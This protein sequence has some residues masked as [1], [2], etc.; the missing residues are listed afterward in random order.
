M[1]ATIPTQET[2]RRTTKD[3][4]KPARRPALA[5]TNPLRPRSSKV[6][7]VVH[8]DSA[9]ARQSIQAVIESYRKS[10]DQQS[11]LWESARVCVAA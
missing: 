11:V 1:T 6:L 5:R 8:G 7:L 10:F 4:S 9:A 2:T 3:A